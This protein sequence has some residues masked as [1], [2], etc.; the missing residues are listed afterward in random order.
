MVAMR[1]GE[2]KGARRR[3]PSARRTPRSTP[4]Q[5]RDPRL[6]A[7]AMVILDGFALMRS[8]TARCA[9]LI[10]PFDLV[11]AESIAAMDAALRPPGRTTARRIRVRGFVMSWFLDTARTTTALDALRWLDGVYPRTPV[12]VYAANDD[13][14]AIGRAC[15]E[16]GLRFRPE[17]HPL[18]GPSFA[19]AALP[20]S[21]SAATLGYV[22]TPGRTLVVVREGTLYAEVLRYFDAHLFAPWDARCVEIRAHLLARAGDRAKDATE[23][24][25]CMLDCAFDLIPVAALLRA[26]G[27]SKQTHHQDLSA[28]YDVWG[29]PALDF[30]TLPYLGERVG[31]GPAYPAADPWIAAADRLDDWRAE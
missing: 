29:V 5:P 16:R 11:L 7:G 1:D 19:T 13:P 21:V 9:R 28:I 6:R 31:R 25:L 22:M 8:L 12:L 15:A 18:V 2:G 30:L 3:R 23:R 26:R 14:E 20:A 10:G 4:A 17:R 24:L 27:V